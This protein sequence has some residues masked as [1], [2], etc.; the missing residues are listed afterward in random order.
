MDKILDID[1]CWECPHAVYMWKH[2]Y[3]ALWPFSYRNVCRV[4]KK[5]CPKGNKI[6]EWCPLPNPKS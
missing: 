3:L 6:P 5:D 4:A 2:W 1:F